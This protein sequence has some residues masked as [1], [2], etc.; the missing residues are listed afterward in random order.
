MPIYFVF[1]FNHSFFLLFR[2]NS[3][4]LECLHLKISK[5]ELYSENDPYVDALLKDMATRSITHAGK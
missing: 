1:S 4:N 2:K 5:I 3:T